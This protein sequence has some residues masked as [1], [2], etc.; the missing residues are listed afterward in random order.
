M[1][2][3]DLLTTFSLPNLNCKDFDE[4]KS[5]IV[6]NNISHYT[7]DH[8]IRLFE[9]KIQECNFISIQGL[10]NFQCKDLILGCQHFI[11]N[12]LLKYN[13]KNIQIFEHDYNYY[14]ILEPRIKYTTINTLEKGKPL[15]IAM[16][17]PGHLSVHNNFKD[18]LKKCDE[19]EI[20]VH[21]DASWLPA[22]FGINY[23]IENKCIKSIAMS[24]SK[25]FCMGWNRIGVRWSK[26]QNDNDSISIMNKF[27]M[28]N[29]I[30]YQ[31][32]CMYLENYSLDHIVSLYKN[33]YDA[34]CKFLKLRPSNIIHA[35]FSI[36]KNTLYG[37]K[38]LLETK[39]N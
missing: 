19:L 15:L 8:F 14:K 30:S 32:G 36:D 13:I 35:M 6:Y 21:I 38:K 26:L 20:D 23:N 37:V 7:K 12:L 33:D 1:W 22:S 25:A 31:I 4:L 11:D 27:N 2:N 17:F 39:H 24:L 3:K 9:N 16:P 10:D 5:S 18:I 29:K 28:I 34:A